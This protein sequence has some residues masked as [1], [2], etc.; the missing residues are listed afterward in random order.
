M[1]QLVLI[2]GFALPLPLCAE[3]LAPPQD[4]PQ[5]LGQAL[6]AAEFETY[7]LGKTLTYGANGAVWGQEEYLPDRQVV[8]AFTGEPCEYGHWTEVSTPDAGPMIC[9]TYEQ[10]PN[11]SCWQFFKGQS[12]LVAAFIG[13]QAPELAE[14]A[15]TEQP[16]QCPG[17]KVG[18]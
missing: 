16:M 17:P 4:P 15:Q 6:T 14:V 9:F 5:T 10:N 8:W 12:G 2:L 18:V 7:A 1:K 11:V 3:P 13:G